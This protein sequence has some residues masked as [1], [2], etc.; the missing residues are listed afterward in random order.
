[1]QRAVR[2][3]RFK[4]IR[5]PKAD[6]AQL[7]DLAADPDE[8]SDL[9][10]RSD[11]AGTVARMNAL[12]ERARAEMGDAAAWPSAVDVAVAVADAAATFALARRQ[13]DRGQPS[14]VA[15]SGSGIA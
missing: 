3:E 13:D 5:Y 1:M 7:F 14:A 2:D 8:R 9:A 15:D 6:R 10:A 4:L 11:H 12:L